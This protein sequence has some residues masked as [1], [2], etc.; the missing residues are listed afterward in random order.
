[1]FLGGVPIRNRSHCS[2]GESFLL[3]RTITQILRKIRRCVSDPV[4][5]S[6][7][8]K[9]SPPRRL[10]R[11]PSETSGL[12]LGFA[13]AAITHQ[14]HQPHEAH[15]GDNP[16][17]SRFEDDGRV[18]HDKGSEPKDRRIQDFHATAVSQH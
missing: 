5:R 12:L 16:Q 2:I 1:M 11:T 6:A 3:V 15:G 4:P 7:A 17:G 10:A 14:G 13:E 18:E 9:P 8:K